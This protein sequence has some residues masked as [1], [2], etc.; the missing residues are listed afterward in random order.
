MDTVFPRRRR[1]RA[2]LAALLGC[3]VAA[4]AAA[5]AAGLSF[6]EGV[7][8]D[9][10]EG[11]E[12]Y[13][14]QHWLR[15]RD[16]RPLERLTLYRCPD[17]TAFARKRVDYRRSRL[18]PEFELT[19]ARSGYREGLRRR[20]G[21]T[22]LYFRE[23]A[24]APESARLLA[25]AELVADAGFDEFIRRHWAQLAAGQRL[26]LDFAVPARLRS[27]GF[28]VQRSGAPRTLA[29][30][31]AITFRLALGGM[32]R[33]IAPHIEVSYGETSRRL[34]RFEGLANLR[35][36]GGASQW[37]ARIDFAAPPRPASEADWRL[38]AATAL[39]GCRGGQRTDARQA[40]RT[41]DAPVASR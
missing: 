30:E 4:P 34:L 21:R 9:P 38:A 11:L 17:G 40:P 36:E 33:W 29:G 10:V 41:A 1:G 28:T 13:R 5:G 6:E 22:T 27:L 31:S 25:A 24:G 26:P 35:D 8:R 32:L 23:H 18:S 39:S 7:A 16:G 15:H 19:D 14:E 2:W 37:V 3:L 20:D 12:L